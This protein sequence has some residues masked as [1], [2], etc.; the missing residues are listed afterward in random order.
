MIVSTQKYDSYEFSCKPNAESLLYAEA[1]PRMQK[2]KIYESNDKTA[3]GRLRRSVGQDTEQLV[4][5]VPAGTLDDGTAA[6]HE[7][8]AAKHRGVSR[9]Q[10]LHRRGTVAHL[11]LR[12]FMSKKNCNKLH[13][14]AQTAVDGN[15]IVKK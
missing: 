11:R 1:K 6:S 15:R 14:T 9:R 3:V 10:A 2:S 12:F 13:D 4:P 7:S 5:A 8:A